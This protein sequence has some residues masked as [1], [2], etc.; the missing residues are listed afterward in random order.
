[1][2][3]RKERGR[4]RELW[5]HYK[6]ITKKKGQVAVTTAIKYWR[7]RERQDGRGERERDIAAIK[8]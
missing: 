8:Y 2:V 4:R 7:D 3:G 6:V 1:M 5:S